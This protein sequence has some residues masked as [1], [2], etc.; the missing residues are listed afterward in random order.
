MDEESFISLH[1]YMRNYSQVM[2]AEGENVSLSQ[3]LASW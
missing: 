3:G 1:S 2:A